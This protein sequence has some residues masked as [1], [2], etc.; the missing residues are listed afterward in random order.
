MDIR[1]PTSRLRIFAGSG[2]N[3]LSQ[4]DRRHRCPLVPK[5]TADLLSGVSVDQALRQVELSRTAPT[6]CR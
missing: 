2:L 6:C 3:Q 1:Q 4:I 5:F